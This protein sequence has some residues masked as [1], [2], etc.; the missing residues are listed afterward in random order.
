M[1][2]ILEDLLAIRK[3]REQT[4][5]NKML[6]AKEKEEKI[7]KLKQKKAAQLFEYKIWRKNEEKQLFKELTRQNR[8]CFD[9]E[10]FNRLVD[11]M[12]QKQTALADE[13]KQTE[14]MVVKAQKKLEETQQKYIRLYRAKQKL[15]EHKSI[16]LK[17]KKIVE[18]RRADEELDEFNTN[19]GLNRSAYPI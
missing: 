8:S 14:Q 18:E 9:I 5:L 16:W 12:R 3:H 10:S 11:Y 13:L 19:I 1:N 6:L 2:Y 7:R 15:E 17:G 4:A